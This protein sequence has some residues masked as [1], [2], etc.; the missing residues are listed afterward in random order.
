MRL[1][2][3]SFRTWWQVP[4]NASKQI[5][6]RQVSF[7]E[8]FYDLVYV[9]LIAQLAHDLAYHL[10]WEGLGTFVFLFVIVWW[11]WN[12]GTF[13]HDLHGN[14]DM[15][16]RVFTFLQMFAVVG[17]AIFAHDAMGKNSVGFALSYAAFQFILSILWWRTGVHDQEHRVLVRPFLAG[18]AVSTGLFIASVFVDTSVRYHLWALAV[19][20]SFIFPLL[21]LVLSGRNPAMKAQFDII[22]KGTPSLVERVG[23]FT[24]I[25]VGE[26]VI[27]VVAGASGKEL[28]GRT[29]GAA[30]LG[31]LVA[32]AIWWVYFDF[33]SHRPHHPGLLGWS[34]WYYLHLPMVMAIAAVGAALT[35]IIANADDQL[36]LGA[37]WL[38]LGSLAAIL[39]CVAFLTHTVQRPDNHR[40]Y[41]RAGSLA[42]VAS[43]L[44]I[45]ATG[46][47]ELTTLAV[48]GTSAALLLAPVMFGFLTWLRSA[49][50][51][52]GVQT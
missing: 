15:R 2:R 18:Y 9:A 42:M 16:T 21:M 46:A 49:V 11:A 25:V 6:H 28:T 48:I 12:N 32:I 29:A 38:F 34:L 33:I 44:V 50:G 7:L 14:N 23:L 36:L 22:S 20:I 41:L 26:V 5:E 1:L 35:S 47:L 27:G 31:T 10:T 43:A 8:L 51:N 24:I 17:M 3:S 4:R 30:A 13:Y 40:S 45:L 52:D 37:K 19:F 39:L